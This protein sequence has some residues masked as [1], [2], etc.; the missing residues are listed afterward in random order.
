MSDPRHWDHRCDTP[1][2]CHERRHHVIPRTDC[3]KCK[4]KG[5]IK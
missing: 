2:C 5:W 3:G 4:Q 1:E